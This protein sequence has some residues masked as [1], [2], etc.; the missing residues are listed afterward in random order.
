MRTEQL[1]FSQLLQNDLYARKVIPHIVPDYFSTE[2]DKNFYKIYLRYFQKH[3]TIPSKQ[4][5]R[6]EIENLK[7]ST[8]VYK[9]LLEVINSTETF[10]ENLDY[11][12]DETEKFCKSRA[13]YNALRESVLIVDGQDKHKTADAIPSILQEALSVCFDTSVGHNYIEDADER[14]EYYHLAEAKIPTGSTEFDKVT[15]GGFSRKTLNLLLAP[16]HGGKSLVMVN[17]GCGALLAGF[18]VLF[19]TLEMSEM[20]MSKRF[21]VNLM[22]IDFDTLE[23]LPK[24]IFQNKFSQVAKQSRGKL[25]VKEYPTGGAHT[26]HFRSLLEELK[27]K[28]NY[29]PDLIIVD[30]LGICASEKYKASSGA[31]SY[32][33]YKSVGEE[34]RALAVENNLAVISAIQTNRAGVGNSEL[35]MSEISESLGSAM[36]ADFICAI[37]NTE[38]LKNLKQILFKLIKNRYAGLA[39]D[40]FILGVDYLR[41]RLHSL[42]NSFAAGS[43]VNKSKSKIETVN[44]TFGS[45]NF[46]I[47]MLHTIKPVKSSFDDFNFS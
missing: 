41:M 15:K 8:D 45:D 22:N 14:Y 39:D 9:S 46:N 10:N 4:A 28:Q 2:E 35:T 16:P 27:T 25:I 36:T 34:L 32:T 13:I 19:I 1:I 26:G 6:V 7:G 17:M 37:I 44:D 11:L 20:E 21:D 47:D 31:N 42:E 30:Y 43:K 38:E 12:V 3:N 5:I 40:K 24:P 29:V 18:N 23:T 33:I